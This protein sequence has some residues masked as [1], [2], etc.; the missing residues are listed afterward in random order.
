MMPV[1]KPTVASE[2]DPLGDFTIDFVP[3]N[4]LPSIDFKDA[5][6]KAYWEM[7]SEEMRAC[8][9]HTKVGLCISTIKTNF[10][11]SF[12]KHETS[13]CK[14][15]M[16]IDDIMDTEDTQVQAKMFAQMATLF[17]RGP[18]LSCACRYKCSQVYS[19]LSL[20]LSLCF[21]VPDHY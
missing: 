6:E 16:Q 9:S 18:V 21:C 13:L 20:S 17:M 10:L 14:N 1:N 19:F 12:N 4:K 5:V 11:L 15:M 3:C 8:E 2:Y 7:I